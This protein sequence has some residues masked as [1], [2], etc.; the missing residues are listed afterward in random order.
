MAVTISFYDKAIQ[1]GLEAGAGGERIDY[2]AGPIPAVLMTTTHSFT[3]THQTWSQISTNQIAAGNGYT[4]G[5]K[6]LAAVT[7]SMPAGGTV[8]F[9]AD[10]VTWTATGGS[11]PTSGTAKY[12]V[13]YFSGTQTND[14]MLICNVDFGQTESAGNGTDFR[15]TWHAN[16]I[17]RIT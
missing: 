1:W 10:D 2:E 11:I 12:C 16:G 9:D 3:K 4:A 17:Y 14:E 6:N 15:I 5:G 8:M 13:L 7:I